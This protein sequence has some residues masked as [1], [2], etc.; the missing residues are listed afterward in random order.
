MIQYLQ[1]CLNL[2][3]VAWTQLIRVMDDIHEG[4]RKAATSTAKTLSKVKKKQIF[5]FTIYVFEYIRVILFL[6]LVMC[7]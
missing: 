6:F 5:M 3:I 2:T 1:K 4:T 7:E